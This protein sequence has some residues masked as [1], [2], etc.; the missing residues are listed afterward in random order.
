MAVR[1]LTVKNIISRVRQ[2][3]PEAPENYLY[4]LINDALLEAGLYRTKVEYAKATTV[5][6]QQWYTLSDANSGI[7]VNKVFRVDFQDSAGDYIKLPR[8]VD[9]E[10]LKM[11]IT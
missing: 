10:I 9:N 1:R 7:D 3:F 5:A 2:T 8:L 6:D 11:D 4:N